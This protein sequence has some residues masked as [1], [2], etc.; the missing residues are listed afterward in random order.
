[1][2][3]GRR[4]KKTGLPGFGTNVCIGR[5]KAT[6]V[7]ER[8]SRFLSTTVSHRLRHWKKLGEGDWGAAAA[9]RKPP[10]D[11]SCISGFVQDDRMERESCVTILRRSLWSL[12]CPGRHN[13]S[14]VCH[15][16][17]WK[18][19][20]SSFSLDI[21]RKRDRFIKHAFFMWFLKKKI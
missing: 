17:G 20:R 14:R 9:D 16:E 18:A 3:V 21:S 10:F 19:S 13:G 12:R 1:M 8:P 2:V 6:M 11:I 4:R 7:Y 15:R 5:I